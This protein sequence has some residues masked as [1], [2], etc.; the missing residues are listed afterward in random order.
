MRG[1]AAAEALMLDACLI[2]R[3]ASEVTDADGNV[4]PTYETV[5][6]GK[7]K[8]SQQTTQGTNP[9]AGGYQYS[10]QGM[11]L[12]VPVGVGPLAVDDTVT[13]T[14]ATFDPHLVGMVLRVT[15]VFRESM[16]TA[17]RTSVEWVAG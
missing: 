5:Y 15:S 2:G 1:R 3:Q 4:T 12:D 6:E 14:A 10:V 13:I 9:E 7:C 8:V 11:R 17:Q 16:A